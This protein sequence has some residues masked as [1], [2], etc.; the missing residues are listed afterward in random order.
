VTADKRLSEA[1][2]IV[3]GSR[4]KESSGQSTKQKIGR[5]EVKE[6]LG[7]DGQFFV[8]HAKASSGSLAIQG[9]ETRHPWQVTLWLRGP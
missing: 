4:Q 9:S 7:D 5:P 1:A 3:E 8:V 2:V 6:A